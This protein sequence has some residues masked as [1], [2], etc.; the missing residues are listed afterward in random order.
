MSNRD[1]QRHFKLFS[2]L[3]LCLVGG[4][5]R[6]KYWLVH[7]IPRGIDWGIGVQKA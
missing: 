6:E 7:L 4:S 2:S 3:R 1:W 5:D